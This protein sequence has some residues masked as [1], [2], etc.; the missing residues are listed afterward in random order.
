MNRFLINIYQHTQKRPLHYILFLTLLVRLFYLS[1]HHPLWWD[2]HVYIGMGKYIFSQGA[3][4]IWESYRPLIHPFLIGSFWYLGI[5]PIVAG[6]IL[7]LVFSL[8]AVLL[9][10]SIARKIFNVPIALLSALIL[11]LAPLFIMFTG[12]ILTEPLAIVLALTGLFLF[13]E[14]SSNRKKFFAGILFSLSFLTK[15]PQGIFFAAACLVIL[16]NKEKILRKI[17]A[18]AAIT[19]GFLLP[20]IPY[21]Y[22]NHILYHNPFEPF[23]SGTMIVT[24]ATWLYGSGIT[25]YFT[26]FFLATPLYLFFFSYIYLFIKEK[27]YQDRNQQTL[28]YICILTLLYFLYVPRKEVRYLVTILP[29]LA[30]TVAYS[31]YTITY[32]LKSKRHPFIRP[33]AF[34]TVWIILLIITIP[35]T[36]Y[37]EQPPTFNK[38][39]N[40]IIAKN[41]LTGTILTSDPSFVSFLDN[42]LILLSGM[43]FAEIIYQKSRQ[44]YDLLFVNDCD[45]IC[46]PNDEICDGRRNNLLLAFATENQEVFK[47]QTTFKASNRTCTY[48]IYLPKK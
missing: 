40:E 2:S 25:Y 35:T 7:D 33:K 38:E 6:T 8:L 5:D 31:I 11:S 28:L 19:T 12:L 41:N 48:S 43:E 22:F 18:L 27:R 37:Y 1:L 13:L 15:F 32:F 34:F 4:G 9:T 14:P 39:L 46:P 20:V 44:N 17:N 23:V 30:I 29:L 10:Y 36:L 16:I 24:T 21:L 42:H 47:T 3:M 26:H 45:L